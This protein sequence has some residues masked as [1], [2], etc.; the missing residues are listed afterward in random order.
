MN[1]GYSGLRIVNPQFDD[2]DEARKLA[3]HADEFLASVEVFDSLKAAIADA[4]WVVGVSGRARRHPERKQPIGPKLLIDRLLAL[5]QGSR[6]ALV[7]GCER[8][9][10]TNT[11]LGLCQDVLTLP[12]NATYPSMNLAHAVLTVAWTI[13]MADAEDQVDPPSRQMVSVAEL[14][15]LMEHAEHTLGLIDYLNPQNPGLILND[16]RKIFTR[17]LLD[18]RELNMLRGIFHR[19]DVWIARQG[20]Q[21]TPNQPRGKT[22]R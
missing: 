1:C 2:W 13:R 22:N 7:F 17:S 11:Q 20:G 8:T 12:T 15:G 9:G 6:T 21:P 18:S 16:L 3:V 10:L 19:M 5:P 14:D 4:H